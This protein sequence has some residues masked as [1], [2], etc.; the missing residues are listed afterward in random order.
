MIRL[1]KNSIR[2]INVTDSS[3]KKSSYRTATDILR[4]GYLDCCVVSTTDIQKNPL[5]G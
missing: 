2:V 1:V 3:N 4:I 5:M